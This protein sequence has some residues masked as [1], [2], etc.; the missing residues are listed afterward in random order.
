MFDDEKTFHVDYL[1]R[2]QQ[3]AKRQAQ[4]QY[5]NA[6]ILTVSWGI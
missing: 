6:T 3:E 1:C 5:P 4:E 2:T